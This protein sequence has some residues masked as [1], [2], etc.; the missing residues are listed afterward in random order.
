M[1]EVAAV[2]AANSTAIGQQPPLAAVG[3]HDVDPAGAVGAA[4]EGDLPPVGRPDRALAQRVA[5]Q[6]PLF[7]AVGVDD[8]DVEVEPDDLVSLPADEQALEGDLASVR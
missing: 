1:A 6:V 3:V 7:A 2:D 5:R 8:V 4:P